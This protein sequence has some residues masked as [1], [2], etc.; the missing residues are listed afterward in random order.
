MSWKNVR[1][2]WLKFIFLVFCGIFLKNLFLLKKSSLSS[3]PCTTWNKVENET[4]PQNETLLFIPPTVWHDKT[5]K[6]PILY[7]CSHKS[8]INSVFYTQCLTDFSSRFPI[9]LVMPQHHLQNTYVEPFGHSSYD[10]VIVV[11]AA[12][13][14]P[15]HDAYSSAVWEDT[16]YFRSMTPARYNRSSSGRVTFSLWDAEIKKLFLSNLYFL[17]ATAV[18]RFQ[19]KLFILLAKL[20]SKKIVR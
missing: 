3:T 17:C 11:A 2:N 20:L 10:V 6:R 7:Q 19:K 1:W 13:D 14:A 15:S 16:H 5:S 18:E 4:V 9:P 8:S 12:A